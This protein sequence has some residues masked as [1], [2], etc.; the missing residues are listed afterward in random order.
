M[1]VSAWSQ[2][3][4]RPRLW[5]VFRLSGLS[6]AQSSRL[7]P[8]SMPSVTALGSSRRGA[9]APPPP[10]LSRPVAVGARVLLL[11]QRQ[12]ERTAGDLTFGLLLLAADVAAVLLHEV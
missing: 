2:A 5:V 7:R 1:S 6:G 12:R 9:G 4:D 11:E 3:Q 8:R 10:P